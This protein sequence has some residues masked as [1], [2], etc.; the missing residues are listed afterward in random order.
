M[1]GLCFRCEYRARYYEEG[2]GPRC[3]CKEPDHSVGSCY[4]YA[5]VHPCSLKPVKGDNRPIFGPAFI[6]ARMQRVEG[7]GFELALSKQKKT[8]TLYWRPHG[9]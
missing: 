2:E 3:E 4:M 5:P 7:H 1:A 6:G 9:G 8:F